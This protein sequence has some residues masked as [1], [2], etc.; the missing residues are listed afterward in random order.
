[1]VHPSRVQQAPKNIAGHTFCA[2]I[3]AKT[4][5][6]NGLPGVLSWIQSSLPTPLVTKQW[7]I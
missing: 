5:P 2:A 7:N 3:S 4:V 1:M 6:A